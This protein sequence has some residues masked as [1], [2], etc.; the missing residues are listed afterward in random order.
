[1]S[2]CLFICVCMHV[3]Y[4]CLFICVHMLIY[5]SIYMYI[6][7]LCMCISLPLSPSLSLSRC[8]SL[9][10]SLSLSYTH[11]HERTY[12]H[13]SIRVYRHILTKSL[14]L[15]SRLQRPAS[16][17]CWSAA[18]SPALFCHLSP[19]KLASPPG[20]ASPQPPVRNTCGCMFLTNNLHKVHLS[21]TE[22]VACW[23]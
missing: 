16:G 19:P 6:S 8:I 5:M 4:I 7:C 2:A 13:A 22:C 23:V 17:I 11:T 15:L 18:K 3:S 1:M 10:L 9:S 20:T 14:P 21:M 12:M